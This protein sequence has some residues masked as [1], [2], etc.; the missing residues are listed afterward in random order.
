MKDRQK[1]LIANLSEE[2]KLEG[3]EASVN[4]DENGPR[5]TIYLDVDSLSAV[6]LICTWGDEEW[7]FESISLETGE[8]LYFNTLSQPQLPELDRTIKQWKECL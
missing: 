8:T 3:F 6:A 4:Y 2:L 5:P 1:Q 7:E